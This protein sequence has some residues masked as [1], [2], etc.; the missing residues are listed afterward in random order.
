MTYR[1]IVKF[2]N[3]LRVFAKDTQF[4]VVTHNKLTMKNSDYLYGITQEEEGVSQVVSVRL[5]G[6]Q[7]ALPQA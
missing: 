5:E 6:N 4:I 3:A 1:N 7:V 2:T